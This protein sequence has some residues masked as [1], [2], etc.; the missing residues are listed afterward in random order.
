MNHLKESEL[1]DL[2]DNVLPAGRARHVEEC[3]VCRENVDALRSTLGRVSDVEVPEPS[4][5]FWEHFSARV[6]EGVRDTT[7]D[8]GAP[9]FHWWHHAG[10][11]WAAA[12]LLVAVVIGV[13]A[14]IARIDVP[15]RPGTTVASGPSTSPTPDAVASADDDEMLAALDGSMADDDVAWG[16]VRAIADE[17]PWDDQVTANLAARPATVERAA[18]S[19]KGEARVEL[20][21]LLEAETKRPGA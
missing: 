21:R 4:P 16:V 1:V 9:W 8:G 19:L 2:L 20:I 10:L 5:L 7:P 18:L 15:H 17:V 12:G 3:A 14:R 13:G 11:K 6:R